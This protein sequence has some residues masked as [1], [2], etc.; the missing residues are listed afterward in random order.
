MTD[1][2]G[3]CPLRP[4]D[5]DIIELC[6]F[7]PG[8]G[9]SIVLHL[10]GMGWAIID[11]CSSTVKGKIINL[12]LAYLTS[13]Y[14]GVSPPPI[15]FL[16][17]T[18]PH[19]DH[20]RHMDLI[21]NDYPGKIERICYPDGKSIRELKE[22]LA[23]ARGGAN[24]D[25]LPGLMAVF[26]AMRG[27]WDRGVDRRCVSEFCDIFSKNNVT[28]STGEKISLKVSAIAPSAE[29]IEAYFEIL[30]K[31]WPQEGKKFIRLQERDI[32]LISIALIINI[33]KMSIILGGDV[34]TSNTKL[35]GWKCLLSKNECPDLSANIVK[36]A[37]HGSINAFCDASWGQHIK[38]KETVAIITPFDRSGLPNEA[39]LE[40]LKKI[41]SKIGITSC[42][43]KTIKKSK[44]YSKLVDNV[45]DLFPVRSWKSLSQDAI[46]FIRLRYDTHGEPIEQEAYGD[47][48]WL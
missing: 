32:N 19:E 7:G 4:P 42:G 27:A 30:A 46:G 48:F 17:L 47:S 35:I 8:I 36:V 22:Y 6:F 38:N 39:T 23:R 14:K 45:T 5:P 29:N 31:A 13:L 37:H 15:A 11:S 28:L 43:K 40:E 18:H 33:G 34:E 25:Q 9:E 24:E 3:K 21:I 26:D 10:P 44:I 20:Y 2:F 41:C 12:P 1:L 16:L